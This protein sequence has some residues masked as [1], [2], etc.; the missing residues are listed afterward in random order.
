MK[1]S[2]KKYGVLVP[3]EYELKAGNLKLARDGW[4]RIGLSL[5][6]K[7]EALNI[8]SNPSSSEEDKKFWEEV[9]ERVSKCPSKKVR[10]KNNPDKRKK[11]LISNVHLPSSTATNDDISNT[12]H[13]NINDGDLACGTQTSDVT[14]ET[15]REYL[16]T[17][18]DDLS[19]LPNGGMGLSSL[20]GKRINSIVQKVI[21]KLPYDTQKFMNWASRSDREVIEKFNSINPYGLMLVLNDQENFTAGSIYKSS[22]DGQKY[23]VYFCKQETYA[24][25]N[26]VH[27]SLGKRLQ[28]PE[29]KVLMVAYNGSNLTVT[30]GTTDPVSK[31]R[32]NVGRIVAEWNNHPAIAVNIVDELAFL[33]QY[34]DKDDFNLLYSEHGNPV[35]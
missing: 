29:V 27:Y 22:V 7:T 30:K 31:F 24:R 4:G 15:V 8:I 5:E 18:I 32:Q 26:I 20:H 17:E 34:H 9:I 33:P 23:S 3:I 10:S 21:D 12:V 1:E 16:L 13:K 25:Q 19:K 2:I 11:A 14:P 28:N 6:L 35:T